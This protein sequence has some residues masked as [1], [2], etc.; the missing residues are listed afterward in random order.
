[1]HEKL[2]NLKTLPSGREISEGE[3]EE[4]REEKRHANIHCTCAYVLSTSSFIVCK[5][6]NVPMCPKW[7]S[8]GAQKRLV[9]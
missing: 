9:S 7:G 4:L 3:E 5:D 8:G 1:M 2:Q 6:A